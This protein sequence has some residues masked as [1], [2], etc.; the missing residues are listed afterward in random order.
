MNKQEWLED[1]ARDIRL[2][3]EIEKL[4]KDLQ[5]QK[6]SSQVGLVNINKLQEQMDTIRGII[7]YT[8]M[9]PSGECFIDCE[10]AIEKIQKL[11]EVEG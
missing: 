1:Y 4:K 8:E 6:K 7:S 11:L 2:Q 3:R 9:T 5:L 10:E